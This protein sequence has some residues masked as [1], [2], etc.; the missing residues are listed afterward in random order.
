MKKRALTR[1]EKVLLGFLAVLLIAAAYYLLVHRT[2]VDTMARIA[3]EKQTIETEILINEAKA[4]KLATMK[5]EL[6]EIESQGVKS[7]VPEY[8]NLSKEIVFLNSILSGTT[9]YTINFSSLTTTEGIARRVTNLEFTSSSYT[10]SCKIIEE[11]QNCEY[12]CRLGDVIMEPIAQYNGEYF[13]VV[14]GYG[15]YDADYSILRN[16]LS[17]KVSMTFYEKV[18]SQEAAAP[19]AAPVE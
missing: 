13:S 12:C 10:Q 8:D 4:Q 16:P 6:A 7:V 18:A 19:E 3:A 17:V 14:Q 2:V 9:D 15:S 1:R 5:K 11:L